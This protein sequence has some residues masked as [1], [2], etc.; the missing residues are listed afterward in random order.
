VKGK[1]I[2]L[3]LGP[4]MLDVR[5]TALTAEERE[6][7]RHPQ[8]GGVILFARNFE[9]PAQVARLIRS[10]KGLRVP[11]LLV[12]VDQEGGRVQRFRAGF[13]RLPPA[14]AYGSLYDRDAATGLAAAEAG[15]LVM[16]A[17]LRRVGVDVSFAPVLDVAQVASKVI[18]DRAFHRTAAVVA[19]LAAAFGRGMR[20]GGLKPVGKHFPGHGGVRGDSHLSLPRD[21]RLYRAVSRCDLLPYRRLLP[22]LGGV[23]SAHVL[24]DTVAP[25]LPT[26]SPFWLRRVLRKRLGF[27]GLVFSDDLSMAGAAPAGGAAQRAQ[28]ALAAGCDMVLVCNDVSAADAILTGLKRRAAPGLAERQRRLRPSAQ[29]RPGP[30][31][32]GKARRTLAC[33]PGAE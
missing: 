22:G 24:F 21:H 8:A 5:G 25:E 26:Y 7:L 11:S 23:M 16:A 30:A 29:R 9:S 18:G 4:V 32:L 14:A 27:D 2:R 17:E 28:L 12:A 31:A 3:R 1:A 10:I 6:R 33:M 13:T 19:D 15:G 20:R